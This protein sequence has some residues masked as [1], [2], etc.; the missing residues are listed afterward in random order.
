MV[1]SPEKVKER[2]ALV[3]W[4]RRKKIEGDLQ[5]EH[6]KQFF[7]GH[8]GLNDKFYEN[9]KLLDVGCGPRGSLEWADMAHE[10]V[11]LD[12]FATSYLK[13]GADKHEMDYVSAYAED[14]PFPDGYFDVVSSFNSFDHVDDVDKSINEIARVLAPGGTFLL[15][16]D[17]RTYPTVCEPQVFSWDIVDKL[18]P[19]FE[20]I[21]VKHYE[22]SESGIYESV[23]AGVEYDHS[24]PAERKGV[25]T[26]RFVRR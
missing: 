25:L 12:P 26:G 24:D 10:R 21:E 20:A 22:E 16:T 2:Y 8:F 19:F 13:L 18:E 1:S 23:L 17:I 5:H 15:I 7:T 11:G 9:K 14:M 4:K 3:H 6:F